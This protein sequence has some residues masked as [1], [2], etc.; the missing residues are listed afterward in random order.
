MNVRRLSPPRQP[1][2]LP[3][4]LRQGGEFSAPLFGPTRR[5]PSSP[6]ATSLIGFARLRGNFGQFGG[7]SLGFLF[8]GE[9]YAEDLWVVDELGEF[10]GAEGCADDGG[11]L[12]VDGYEGQADAFA[13]FAHVHI[14]LLAFAGAEA[15]D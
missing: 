13:C 11:F 3:P 8:V 2:R 10:F 6:R 12:F 5:T 9:R 14:C 4:L 15:E 7:L 1:K